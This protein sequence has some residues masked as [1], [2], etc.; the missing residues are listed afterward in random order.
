M[1]ANPH[2]PEL[3]NRP[4]S[5]SKL[6]YKN[7][8]NSPKNQENF[9][10]FQDYRPKIKENIRNIPPSLCILARIIFTADLP[11]SCLSFS[12]SNTLLQANR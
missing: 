12:Q 11:I 9:E 2:N 5:G 3:Q 7:T 4:K 10:E 1:L 6:F 8:A